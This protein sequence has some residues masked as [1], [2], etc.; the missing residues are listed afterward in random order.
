MPPKHWDLAAGYAAQLRARGVTVP[1]SDLL[2]ATVAVESDSELLARDQH[3]EMIRAHVLNG[4][5]LK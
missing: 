3:F 2:I 4:L 1:A 5:R